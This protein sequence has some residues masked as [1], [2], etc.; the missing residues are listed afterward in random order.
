MRPEPVEGP[1]PVPNQWAQPGQRSRSRSSQGRGRV[2]ASMSVLVVR[3]SQVSMVSSLA[4]AS[5]R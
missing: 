4:V 2:Q 3:C 5:R 1:V